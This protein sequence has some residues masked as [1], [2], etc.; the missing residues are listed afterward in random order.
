[1]VGGDGDITLVGRRA[2]VGAGTE[3]AAGARYPEPED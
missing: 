3:V 2:Q 1:V